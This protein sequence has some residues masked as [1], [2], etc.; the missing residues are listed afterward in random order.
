VRYSP[1]IAPLAAALLCQGCASPAPSEQAAAPAAF[2]VAPPT[3][4]TLAFTVFNQTSRR[5]VASIPRGTR[6]M[7]FVLEADWVL[8]AFSGPNL[9]D[10]SFPRET[11][12]LT[13]ADVQHIWTDLGAAGLLDPAHP[14]IVGTPPA[15]TSLPEPSATV[16]AAWIVT[17]TADGARRMLIL[18]PD[19][20]PAA[21]PLLDRLADLAWMPE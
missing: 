6:P 5:Q 18:S 19:D 8:R 12:Q 14:A 15:I 9:T 16:P 11:R 17:F 21:R 7:R 13:H 4:F 1:I 2:A 10:Q 20:H 3:D